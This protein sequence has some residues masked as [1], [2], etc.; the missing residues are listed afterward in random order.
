VAS[1][2]PTSTE[3]TYIIP[4]QTNILLYSVRLRLANLKLGC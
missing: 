2:P 4:N 3:Y 1:I